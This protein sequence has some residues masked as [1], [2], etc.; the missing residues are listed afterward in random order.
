MV[1]FTH[2]FVLPHHLF[3]TKNRKPEKK[4]ESICHTDMFEK[5]QCPRG[6]LTEEMLVLCSGMNINGYYLEPTVAC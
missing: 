3:S 1:A 6:Y 5:G 2:V 4:N